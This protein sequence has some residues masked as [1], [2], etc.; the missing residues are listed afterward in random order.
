MGLME[1][2]KT[3][4]FAAVWDQLCLSRDVPVGQAW[5]ADVARYEREV[6][7]KRG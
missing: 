1:E 6:L 2:M 7:A 5:M 3:M 4:P